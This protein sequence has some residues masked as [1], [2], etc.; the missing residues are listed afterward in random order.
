MVG[1]LAGD[2]RVVVTTET[3]AHYLQMIDLYDR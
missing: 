1:W 3:G 2:S